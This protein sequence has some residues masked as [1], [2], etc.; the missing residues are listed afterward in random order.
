FRL[1]LLLFLLALQLFSA[2]Q[3][4]AKEFDDLQRLVGDRDAVLLADPHGRVL[5]SQNADLMLVPASTLKLFTALAAFHYLG[6]DYRFATE[7]Y[8]DQ[9]SNLKIKGYG[10]PL[11]ISESLPEVVQTL[12]LRL[13]TR[14][15][16]VND[17]ILDGSYFDDPVVIPGVTSSLEPYDAPNGALCANFN[18]VF[19]RREP[20]GDYRSAEPQTP[21]LPYVRERI[22]A[23]GLDGGRII[24]SGV[25][26]E[27]TRYAGHLL[28]YF[29]QQHGICVNGTI[30]IGKVDAAPDKLILRHFSVF[31]LAQIMAKL[32][33]HSNNFVANQLLIATGAKV[34][35]PPGTL[36]KGVAAASAF[37]KNV[38]KI[39]EIEIVEGSG[40]SR[41]NRISAYSL[42]KILQNF[43]PHY[44]L[45]RHEGNLYYK[46]G[47]LN[48]ISARAGYIKNRDGGLY[49]FVV[50]INTPDKSTDAIMEK[51]LRIQNKDSG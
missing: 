31:S 30:R 35:G 22:L 7:F 48:G 3:I 50:L 1:I 19:F 21:L 27:H 34:F 37:A 49:P 16:T 18:T 45:M 14:N 36:P 6:P 46:T 33:E 15:K 29:M 26:D 8:L 41:E 10:D 9:N 2:N 28:R 39:H 17:L 23:S 20:N 12:R 42:L 5:Y 24:L 11:L 13:N 43:A 51:L 25:N 32:M 44:L 40:I 4:S 38:L 47:T